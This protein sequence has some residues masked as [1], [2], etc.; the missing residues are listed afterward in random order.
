MYI[1]WHAHFSPL[2]VSRPPLRCAGK[3]GKLTRTAMS[4][5]CSE[6]SKP[7]W[8]QGRSTPAW[9]FPLLRSQ[10]HLCLPG[11]LSGRLPAAKPETSSLSGE[12]LG[13]FRKTREPHAA[14]SCSICPD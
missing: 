8:G 6:V 9:L 3:R 2:P 13:G 12:R 4:S 11:G 7:L 1:F 14:L 10:Q 5:P